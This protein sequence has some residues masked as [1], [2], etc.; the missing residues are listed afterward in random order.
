ME[1]GGV[2]AIESIFVNG[3]EFI[4]LILNFAFESL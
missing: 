3:K 4:N 1:R 2:V